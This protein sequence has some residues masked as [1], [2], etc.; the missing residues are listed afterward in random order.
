MAGQIDRFTVV[1]W[2]YVIWLGLAI[3]LILPRPAASAPPV[4]GLLT[5]NIV[6]QGSYGTIKGRLVWGGD[7][8]PKARVLQEKGK[9]EKNPDVC[10][11]D[12]SIL[13]HE[14]EIDPDTKGI[15]YGF[16]YIV[17]PKG[18]NPEA[19]QELLAKRP[20]AEM[21]QKNCDFL[22]HSLAIHEDQALV[23]KSSD[24]TSH[25]VRLAGLTN[26]GFN[27]TVGPNGTLQV[28]LIKER[29]PMEIKCDIHPW[30]HGHVMVFDH[31]FFAVTGPDGS[32]EIKGVPAGEQNMVVWHEKV[33]YASPGRGVGMPVKVAAGEVTDVGEVKIDPAK[34][35]K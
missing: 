20:K 11:K 23:L 26:T 24:P 17:K 10:A 5:A 28:K 2:K 21:D 25:N 32:F 35:V 33:G 15:A 19:I 1:R 30:M 7:T 4:A 14:L 18:T 13:S 12:Q 34:A 6:G 8:V 22:P 3:P 29:L 27:Q 31:T 9:A 16:A